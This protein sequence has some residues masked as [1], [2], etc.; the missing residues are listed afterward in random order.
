[1]NKPFKNPIA[2]AAQ[3][4]QQASSIAADSSALGVEHVISGDYGEFVE[5]GAAD[6]GNAIVDAA[7]DVAEGIGEIAANSIQFG[8]EVGWDIFKPILER[9][10]YIII[11]LIILVL[12]GIYKFLF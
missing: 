6:L 2:Q 3:K 10:W 7:E 11:P 8:F 1:M 12:Y 9:Y 5:A 4:I